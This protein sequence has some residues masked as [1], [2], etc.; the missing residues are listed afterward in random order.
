[1]SAQVTYSIAFIIAQAD[2]IYYPPQPGQGRL[3]GGWSLV[4]SYT[5]RGNNQPRQPGIS[6][7]ARKGPSVCMKPINNSVTRAL[8]TGKWTTQ[9]FNRGVTGGISQVEMVPGRSSVLRR[10]AGVPGG[11]GTGKA[12]MTGPCVLIGTGEGPLCSQPW[13]GEATWM[14]EEVERVF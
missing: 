9:Q 3:R 4:Q 12:G 7:G 13:E 2:S 14:F 5:P 8:V 10:E 6:M 11:G 1:M